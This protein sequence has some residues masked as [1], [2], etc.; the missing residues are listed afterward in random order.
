MMTGQTLTVTVSPAVESTQSFPL[1]SS[2]TSHPSTHADSP[3]V[4][5]H[6]RA[7]SSHPPSW[8]NKSLPNPPAYAV[9]AIDFDLD[10]D[11]NF[12]TTLTFV[13]DPNPLD[14]NEKLEGAS[15]RHSFGARGPGL[16]AWPRGNLWR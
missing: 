5:T 16:K 9:P 8:T 6:T 10:V 1:P 2:T 15:I 7:S 14:T 11:V 12:S 4:A 13:P 3:S